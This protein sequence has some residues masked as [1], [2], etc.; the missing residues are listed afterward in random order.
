MSSTAQCAP[1]PISRRSGLT[2]P[3][4]TP[5][6][7]FGSR[8]LSPADRLDQDMRSTYGSIEPNGQRSVPSSSRRREA[9]PGP[10][11]ERDPIDVDDV[12]EEDER[13]EDEL[14]TQKKRANLAERLKHYALYLELENSGSVA[15]DHLALER[16]FL[17]YARTSLAIASAGVG[18]Q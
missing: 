14:D 3:S 9:I 11:S 4:H 18:E 2:A 16:T 12:E 7:S 13:D 8:S 10:S 15:R 17:A 5:V 1:V 6:S